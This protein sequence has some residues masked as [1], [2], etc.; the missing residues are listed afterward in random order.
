[1]RHSAVLSNLTTFNYASSVC[2]K[3][4]LWHHALGLLVEMR[5][6][7]LLLDVISLGFAPSA[8]EISVQWP[9]AVGLSDTYRCA[10]SFD[11]LLCYAGM[12]TG[13]DFGPCQPAF[14]WGLP[15]ERRHSD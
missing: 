10:W 1:M 4:G 2:E 8:Y 9:Q 7:Q 12:G 5:H 15:G 11:G 14:L 6:N 3:G 13:W